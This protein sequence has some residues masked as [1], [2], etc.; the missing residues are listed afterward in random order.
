MK[1]TFIT[2]GGAAL[3]YVKPGCA[4]IGGEP[5]VPQD[6]KAEGDPG[7]G[8][9]VVVDACLLGAVALLESR[10]RH[11]RG[12]NRAA[13]I[14]SD[15]HWAVIEYIVPLLKPFMLVQRALEAE[16]YVTI[17]LVV[18]N[19]Q[20]RYGLVF[21]TGWRSCTL[22][23]RQEPPPARP[24]HERSF[25]PVPSLFSI[26]LIAVRGTAVPFSSTGPVRASSLKASSVG[27]WSRLL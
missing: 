4:A 2:V 7:R 12:V 8:D 25:S 19:I 3:H 9:E 10:D 11:A 22:N 5:E 1:E 23:S 26:I 20:V 14:F 18:P 24:R 16:K 17:S 27:S 6:A 21:A 13:R 15:K